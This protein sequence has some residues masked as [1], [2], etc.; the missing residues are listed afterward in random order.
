ML[1]VINAIWIGPKLGPLHAACLESFLRQGHEVLLHTF[2]APND[3]PSGVKLFD[4]NRL[5][6]RKDIVA[7]RAT[8]SLSLA[9]DI[10]RYRILRAGMGTYVDCDVYCLRPLPKQDYLFGLEDDQKTC[11]A[12]LKAPANS[13]L[14]KRLNAAA[15][16]PHYI[17]PWTS[18]ST[19][20]FLKLRRTIRCP[21]PVSEMKWGT[22]G[23]LLLTYLIDKLGLQR[24]RLPIDAFYALHY[25]H[26]SLLFQ[27]GLSL[28]SLATPRSYG[29]HLAQSQHRS[30]HWKPSSPLAQILGYSG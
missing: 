18:R 19:R 24:H 15:S 16:D 11:N 5:M 25:S 14:V 12:V 27:P 28:E 20:S 9:S 4:A 17:P 21:K 30:E 8:G 7:H 29:L 3:V 26:T 23:P 22:I 6:S 1:D 10:Y 13:E 2:D